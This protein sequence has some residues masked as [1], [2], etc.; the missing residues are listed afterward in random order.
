M[1]TSPANPNNN[2]YG[3]PVPL[4]QAPFAPV[5]AQRAPTTADVFLSGSV[6]YQYGQI[7]VDQ[8]NDT[9][10]IFTNVSSGDAEWVGV[11]GGSLIVTIDGDSG[12]ATGATISFLATPN[13]GS[14]VA[15]TASGS[16][17][18][19][20]VTDINDNTIIGGGSGN[21]GVASGSSSSNTSLGVNCLIA[22]NGGVSNTAIGGGNLMVCVTNSNNTAVGGAALLSCMGDS[23]TAIGAAALVTSGTGT[24]NTALG[25][26]ALYQ[27]ATGSNNIGIGYNAGSSYVAAESDNIVIGNLGTASESNVIRIGTQGSG[28]GEQDTCFVAGIAGDTVSR[29]QTVTINPSTG[30]LGSAPASLL[31]QW[32]LISASQTLATNNGY[33]CGGGATLSLALPATSAVGDLISITLDGSTGFTVTQG[34]SQQIRL[35]NTQTTAGVGGSISSTAQGDTLNMVCSIAD[36][37]WNVLSSIGN[38]AIV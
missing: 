33:I 35:G 34:A 11:G 1:T 15:F 21:S 30:Q 4:T 8:A 12:S 24:Q 38:P 19:L 3:F 32:S 18:D 10:Y 14:S 16:T 25:F 22:L 6:P 36:L 26:Q 28:D 31:S 13:C 2:L 5:V 37:K 17:V 9:A 29:A 20:N 27:V 23:N 7:W